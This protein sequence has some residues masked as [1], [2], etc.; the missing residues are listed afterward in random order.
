MR[1]L[2][3]NV[4]WTTPVESLSPLDLAASFD[5]NVS[6]WV[7]VGIDDD[8]APARLS[9]AYVEAL[10]SNGKAAQLIRFPAKGHN[11]LLDPDVLA[12][13][14]EVIEDDAG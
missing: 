11:I 5:P 2:H 6:A 9:D 3:P 7:T 13:I 10:H 1:S 8:V 14:D 12:I 4:D